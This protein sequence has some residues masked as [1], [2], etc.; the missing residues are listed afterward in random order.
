M[1]QYSINVISSSKS[2]W[3]YLSPILQITLFNDF[4]KIFGNDN[5]NKDKLSSN[6]FLYKLEKIS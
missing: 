4:K 1:C 6:E 5:N 2:I 3:K